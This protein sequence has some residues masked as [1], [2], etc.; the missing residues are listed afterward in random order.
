MKFK[1]TFVVTLFLI[2]QLFSSYANNKSDENEL[3]IFHA[4]SLTVPFEQIIREF[5][6]ANPTV[7]ILKE[8]AGSRTCA[9]KI[10]ELHKDCDI[11]FSADYKVID[12]LLIPDYTDWNIKFATNEMAVV[13]TDKSNRSDEINKNNWFEILSDPAISFGRSDPNSDPCGYRSIL[14]MKL[15][16]K[17]Y[18]KSDLSDKLLSKDLEYIRPKETD[19]LALLETGE[20]DYIFLYRSVAVQ[21]GLKHL[22]L[23]DEINLKT[24]KYKTL[25]STVNIELIGKKPGEKV[26]VKGEPMIYGFTIPKNA[27]NY[28]LAL[29][30]IHFVLSKDGGLKIL[31]DNGQPTI[32]PSLSESYEKIPDE[33]KKYVRKIELR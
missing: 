10:S 25:Y 21:H 15:A 4:G 32:I 2:I 33:L 3:I 13:F 28:E 24:N 1:H 31:E 11:F 30:F 6:K 27:P 12:N 23:P 20:I 29:R 16:E 19:L 7:S 22:V 9:R 17:Y 18:N 14:T 5:E 26:I 8:I